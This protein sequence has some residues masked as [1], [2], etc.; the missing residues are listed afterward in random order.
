M[1]KSLLQRQIS[2]K[3]VDIFSKFLGFLEGNFWRKF[4]VKSERNDRFQSEQILKM[5]ERVRCQLLENIIADLF[6]E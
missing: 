6:T 4:L 1:F 5:I 3:F 2:G